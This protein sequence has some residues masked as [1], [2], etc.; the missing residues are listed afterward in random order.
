MA[1]AGVIAAVGMATNAVHLVIGA[2][3][4]APGFEPLLKISLSAAAGGGAWKR[5]LVDMARGYGAPV[6][7]AL[8]GSLVLSATGTSLPAGSG[9]YLGTGTLPAYWHELTAAAT[10]VAVVAGLSGAVL[11]NAGRAVLTAGVMIALALVPGAALVGMG[12][13]AGNGGLA[14]EG[15]VRWAHDAFIVVAI[16]TAAFASLRVLRGRRL[17][18][19]GTGGRSLN[20]TVPAGSRRTRTVTPGCRSGGVDQ[21]GPT[22]SPRVD[23][24]SH[25]RSC[26]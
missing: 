11:I 7:G 21:N 14:L 4:V 2:M 12:A 8:A 22:C 5:G 13:A 18:G 23:S 17:H 15:A 3:V 26:R 10:I 9:G 24:R 1:I 20:R 19:A 16:G 6:V 25:R